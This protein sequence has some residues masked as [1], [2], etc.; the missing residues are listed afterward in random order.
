MGGEKKTNWTQI[1]RP[2]TQTQ[3]LINFMEATEKILEWGA[4][5]YARMKDQYSTN[6]E[7]KVRSRFLVSWE[8]RV[9]IQVLVLLL[10]RQESTRIRRCIGFGLQHGSG[11]ELW[12][13]VKVLGDVERDTYPCIW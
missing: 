5:M 11:Q 9:A 4:L 1:F 13:E 2:T 8:V 6:M 7:T 3:I 12:I 10:K